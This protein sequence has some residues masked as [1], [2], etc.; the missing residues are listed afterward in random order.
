MRVPNATKILLGWDD[1]NMK[2]RK[3]CSLVLLCF[4]LNIAYLRGELL[5][6]ILEVGI[7]RLQFWR[8]S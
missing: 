4:L 6:S 3:C 5:E 7:L 1:V 2:W 8:D